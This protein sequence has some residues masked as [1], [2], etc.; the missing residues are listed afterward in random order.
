MIDAMTSEELIDLYP[1]GRTFYDESDDVDGF[2][3]ACHGL[4]LCPAINYPP[5]STGLEP[6]ATVQVPAVKLFDF[7]A[8]DLRMGT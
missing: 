4:D 1:D 8:L 5:P 7:Y 2:I 6:F 3:A